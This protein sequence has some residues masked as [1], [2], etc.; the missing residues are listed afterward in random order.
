LCIAPQAL[1]DKREE[2]AGIG[3]HQAQSAVKRMLMSSQGLRVIGALLEIRS[4]P[5]AA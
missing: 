4:M 1:S 2:P 3:H 5:V